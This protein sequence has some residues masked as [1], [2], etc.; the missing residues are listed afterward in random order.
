MEERDQAR[1]LALIH[2]HLDDG[3]PMT[4][5]ARDAGVPIRT[6]RRWLARFR[7]AGPAGLTPKPRSDAGARKIARELVELI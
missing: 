5:A 2:A 3:V 7:D 1:R 6:A 4:A